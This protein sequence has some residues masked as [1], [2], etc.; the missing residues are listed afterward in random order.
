M[1]LILFVDLMI[2]ENSFLFNYILMQSNSLTKWTIAAVGAVAIGNS[3][4]IQALELSIGKTKDN[5]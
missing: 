3:F 2:V 1:L 5:K 4:S